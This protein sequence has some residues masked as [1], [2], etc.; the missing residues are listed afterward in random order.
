MKKLTA[1]DTGTKSP[2]FVAGNIE[3]LKAL[4]PEAFAE[5]K[6]D[7]EVLKQILGGPV[8]EREENYG[9]NWHGKRRARPHTLYRHPPPLPGG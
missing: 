9:L 5:G 4:F 8:D 6:A 7:F 3:K 1:G 2:D